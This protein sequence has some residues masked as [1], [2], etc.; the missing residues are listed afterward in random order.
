MNGPLC[1][2][3]SI[4]FPWR[5][6]TSPPAPTEPADSTSSGFSLRFESDHALTRLVA[7]GKVGLERPAKA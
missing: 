4:G 5:S 1:D 2:I 3:E 7:A 6:I